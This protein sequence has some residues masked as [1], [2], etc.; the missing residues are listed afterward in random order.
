MIDLAKSLAVKDETGAFSPFR[1]EKLLISVFNSCRHRATAIDDAVALV[2]TITNQLTL[3]AK[4]GHV[5]SA[6]IAQTCH[7]VLGRFDHA[8]AVQYGAFHPNG[9]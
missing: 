2:G 1:K 6:Q 3:L 8:A 4:N 5:T 7:L 9:S